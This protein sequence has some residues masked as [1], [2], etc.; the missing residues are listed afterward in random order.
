MRLIFCIEPFF[1]HA[2]TFG[3]AD[4]LKKNFHEGQISL[5][6]KQSLQINNKQTMHVRH[7][8]KWLTDTDGKM[9]V[10]DISTWIR[11]IRYR[12]ETIKWRTITRRSVTSCTL[13][14]AQPMVTQCVE[15]RIRI[16]LHNNVRTWATTLMLLH[17]RLISFLCF[18]EN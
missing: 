7:M 4:S 16:S 9:A 15:A 11:C 6:S 3:Q 1:L 13:T 17:P 14:W 10:Q 8:K 5:E 12:A 18:I 2:F